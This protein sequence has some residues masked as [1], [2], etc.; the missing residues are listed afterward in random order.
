MGR[1]RFELLTDYVTPNDR[2]LVRSHW[3]P[4]TPDPKK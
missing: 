3:I 4:R 2:F 1:C